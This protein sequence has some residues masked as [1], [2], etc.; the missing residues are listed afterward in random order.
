M[1]DPL[2]PPSSTPRQRSK[3][4]DGPE[5]SADGPFRDEADRFRATARRLRARA[6]EQLV[7]VGDVVIGV[8][9]LIHSLQR[10]RGV[11]N[12]YLGSQGGV[13]ADRLAATTAASREGEAH[14]RALLRRLHD[15]AD[16]ATFDARLYS[17]IGAVLDAFDR[18][19]PVRAR[20]RACDIT[21]DQSTSFFVETVSSLLAVVFE[22][23]DASADPEISRALIAMFNFMQGKEFAG[24]E[25]AIA[26]AGITQ[27]KFT[28]PQHA[29]LLQLID[30]QARSLQLFGRFATEELRTLHERLLSGPEMIEFERLRRIACLASPGKPLAGVGSEQWYDQATRR[31]DAM[32]EV[33]QAI[34]EE[35]RAVCRRKLAE[36]A[37][38]DDMAAPPETP[39]SIA[40]IVAEADDTFLDVARKAG[41]DVYAIDGVSP[42]LGKSIL[43]IVQSQ[44]D[45]LRQMSEEL[46]AAKGAI[47]ERKTIDRAKGLLM[48]HRGLSEPQ[49]YELLRKT[50]MSQNRR[51]KE[52]AEAVLSMA[53]ILKTL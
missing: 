10:E 25:R 43:D 45:H 16:Q 22:A 53:D 1:G 13:F 46:E 30:A 23:S 38:A 4:D 17:R 5:V 8:S 40:F 34:D 24:Q 33:E 14:V 51:M 18:I 9:G 11:S 49:A 3:R 32:R 2:S 42:R 6:I 37:S 41:A 7:M 21:V 39:R 27:G 20:I 52:V 31:I 36:A 35:L 26:A 29:R 44:A 15:L 47:S 28:A 19:E 50:A 12:V 48:T